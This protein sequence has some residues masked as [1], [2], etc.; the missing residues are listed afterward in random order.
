MRHPRDELTSGLQFEKRKKK[1]AE[2]FIVHEGNLKEISYF[3][4]FCFSSS[5]WVCLFVLTWKIT[6]ITS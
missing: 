5:L 6:G 3:C 2:V 4:V 1:K